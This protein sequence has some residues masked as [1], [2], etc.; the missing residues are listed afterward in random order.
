MK[1]VSR[2]GTSMALAAATL[3]VTGTIAVTTDAEASKKVAC[4]GVN[5]CKGHGACKSSANACKG[6]NSCKGMG[7][8]MLSKSKCMAKGGSVRS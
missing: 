1:M 4:Y 5:S 2:S 8:T 6:Q 3:F 7:L